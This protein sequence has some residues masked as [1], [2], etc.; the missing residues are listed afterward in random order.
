MGLRNS[1]LRKSIISL[2]TKDNV[3]KLASFD[4]FT[5]S[6]ELDICPGKGVSVSTYHP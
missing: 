3:S 1:L 2:S 4:S 6:T 5:K